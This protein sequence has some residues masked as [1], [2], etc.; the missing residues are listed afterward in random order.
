MNIRVTFIPQDC[1]DYE[2]DECD[3]D[4]KYEEERHGTEV[5]YCV[6]FDID[7]FTIFDH[8]GWSVLLD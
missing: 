2:G 1:A 3:V 5:R 4:E 8:F 6:S 7:L